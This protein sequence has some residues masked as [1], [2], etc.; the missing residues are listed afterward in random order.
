MLYGLLFFYE[1]FP[2]NSNNKNKLAINKWCSPSQERTCDTNEIV[3]DGG[4]ISNPI[5]Y[6]SLRKQ[7]IKLKCNTIGHYAYIS[8]INASEVFLAGSN[9]NKPGISYLEINKSDYFYRTEDYNYEY[10]NEM[11][12][13]FGD[14]VVIDNNKLSSMLSFDLL[15]PRRP[16][17]VLKYGITATGTG[18]QTDPYVVQ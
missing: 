5:C 6:D 16:V 1:N 7:N 8:N 11:Y 10:V 15:S 17:I 13:W 3:D 4:G 12:T 14:H 18:T 9:Y 2:I